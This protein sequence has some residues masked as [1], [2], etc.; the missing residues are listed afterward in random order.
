MDHDSWVRAGPA[1]GV[2][3]SPGPGTAQEGTKAKGETTAT[4]VPEPPPAMGRAGG[5]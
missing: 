1:T 3:P 4:L 2:H 5:P